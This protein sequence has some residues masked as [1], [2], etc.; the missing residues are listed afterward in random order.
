MALGT[1]AKYYD[2]SSTSDVFILSM[3]TSLSFL[4][5]PALS[6]LA[7]LV[8]HPKMKMH[9]FKRYW[10]KD[11]HSDVQK[12]VETIVSIYVLWYSVLLTF[13]NVTTSFRN[14]MKD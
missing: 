11:L 6:D 5:T 14:A 8:L 4:A 10:D 3:C 13:Y 12:S 2:K 9:Y 7:A 1:I